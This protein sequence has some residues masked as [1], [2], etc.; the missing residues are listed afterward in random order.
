MLELPKDNGLVIT[1]TMGPTTR[2]ACK[3]SLTKARDSLARWNG[4]WFPTCVLENKS[5]LAKEQTEWV[6]EVVC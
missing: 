5:E 2:I 1:L 6:G 3:Q 4:E